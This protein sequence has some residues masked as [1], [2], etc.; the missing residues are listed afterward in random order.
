MTKPKPDYKAQLGEYLQTRPVEYGLNWHL[1]T[2]YRFHPVRRW[3]F[4]FMWTR[5]GLDPSG[6][7]DPTMIAVEYDGGLGMTSHSSIKGIM[8]DQEK[9]NHAQEL[10]WQ[11][12]RANS[13]S[14]RDGSFMELFD[15]VLERIANAG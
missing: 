9:I 10:G 13:A 1:T 8:R 11:V 6:K 15:R 14:V 2:E 12:Y 4:D 7:E 3:R 5:F